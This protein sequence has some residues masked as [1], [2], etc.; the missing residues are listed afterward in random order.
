MRKQ[1][2]LLSLLSIVIF[3][4]YAQTDIDALRYSTP[5]VQGTARNIALGNTMSTIGGDITSVSTNP[6]GIAKFSSTEFT[7]SPGISINLTSS[8]FLDNITKK[9]KIKFQLTNIGIVVVRRSAKTDDTKKWN[10]VKFGFAL[11]NLA[12]Y[13]GQYTFSGYNSKNSLLNVYYEK[14]NDRSYITDSTDAADNYP[15][16][17][18]IAYQLGLISI[19]SSGNTYTATNNGNM[20]QNF[21]IQ[22]SGGINELA[23]GFG[24]AYKDKIMLGISLG[25]PIV[26]YTERIRLEEIDSRDSA[27]DLNSFSNET[28]LKTSGAGFNFKVGIIGMPI[29]NLRLSLSFQTPGVLFMKD[30]YLTHMEVDYASQSV[31]LTGDSPE[32]ASKYKYIQPWKLITGVG[33]IHK[34]GLVAVEYEL[35]DAGGSKFRLNQSDV[36]ANAYENYVNNLIKQ[37]Y[38]LFHT[39]KAGVEFKYDPIRIRGGIQ[40]RTSPFKSASSP[41][42]INTASLTFSAGFGYRGKHFFVDLAYVQTN[43]KEM[44]VPYSLNTDAWKPVPAA[45]L[46][47][48][49][50]MVIVTVGYKL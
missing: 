50:P 46:S 14:L 38:G 21:T 5:I 6:A 19:D 13:T 27:F 49:K 41:S 47:T 16:D 42:N 7:L 4:S 32:G 29:P 33:Y 18:S 8:T 35:S 39:I 11:N 40:Y 20:Q 48:K 25:I 45:T 10:G 22:K 30:A 34:Y 3:F 1:V 15:F 26:G 43:F 44:Y 12:N 28:Y 24:S 23:I 31:I 2:L 17:A 36:N 9:S 37:K